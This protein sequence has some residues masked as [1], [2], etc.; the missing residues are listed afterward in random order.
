M[1]I[2]IKFKFDKRIFLLFFAYN[3]VYKSKDKSYFEIRKKLKK[4]FQTLHSY[5]FVQWILSRSQPPD[6][7]EIHAFKEI[8]SHYFDGFDEILKEIYKKTEVKKAY[9]KYLK[10]YLLFIKTDRRKIIKSIQTLINFLKVKDLSKK[11]IF[12][13]QPFNVGGNYCIELKDKTWIVFIYKQRDYLSIIQH[14]FLH[15]FVNPIFEDKKVKAMVKKIKKDKKLF[16]AT[17]VIKEN[18]PDTEIILIEYFVRAI[19][20][21]LHK[22]ET[23]KLFKVHSKHGFILINYF[24]QRINYY[25]NKNYSLKRVVTS[26]LKELESLD[27]F[28]SLPSFHP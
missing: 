13:P 21:L 7:K 18:Y 4:Y 23:K 17:R 9:Q 24:T 14:E 3:L 28:L 15:F 10:D 22:E 2:Q 26:I 11:I 1:N 16:K 6:L 27:D 20:I 12:A 5:N 8:S 25:L 19:S